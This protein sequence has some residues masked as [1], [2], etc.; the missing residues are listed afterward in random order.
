M[1]SEKLKKGDILF[2]KKD[3]KIPNSREYF[4][5]ENNF[6]EVNKSASIGHIGYVNVKS[7]KSKHIYG[8]H[9]TI[10]GEYFLSAQKHRKL[11]LKKLNE[12]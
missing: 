6:Y 7:E 11:K 12:I 2:C 3:K 8:F 5:I 10:L 9:Y 1:W 4:F